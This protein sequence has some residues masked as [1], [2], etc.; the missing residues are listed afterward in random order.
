MKKASP[1]L[2]AKLRQILENNRKV[3]KLLQEILETEPP[4]GKTQLDLLVERVNGGAIDTEGESGH[5]RNNGEE[6][7]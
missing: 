7:S 5:E 6:R 3:A 1:E 4:P 2:L